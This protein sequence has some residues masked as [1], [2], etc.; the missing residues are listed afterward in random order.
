VLPW[1]P[2]WTIM[3]TILQTDESTFFFLFTDKL[4]TEIDAVH[5]TKRFSKKIS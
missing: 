3:K 2:K 4:P 1:R 5:R